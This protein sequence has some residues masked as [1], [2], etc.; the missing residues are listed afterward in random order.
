MYRILYLIVV[1][2]RHVL[3]QFEGRPDVLIALQVETRQ[4]L[5]LHV[6]L[7]QQ[8]LREQVHEDQPRDLHPVLGM[9]QVHGVLVVGL[10][11]A[12]E[13]PKFFHVL[14]HHGQLESDLQQG[15]TKKEVLLKTNKT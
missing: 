10:Q 8:V 12:A 15:P 1:S 3:F 9:R 13:A 14:S 2:Q 5:Q 11:Q 7:L 4:L 6:E